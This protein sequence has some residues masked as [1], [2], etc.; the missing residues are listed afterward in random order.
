M[1]AYFSSFRDGQDRPGTCIGHSEVGAGL[2]HG[3]ALGAPEPRND[4]TGIR[5]S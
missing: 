1:S 4:V 5:S 2:Y 3:P